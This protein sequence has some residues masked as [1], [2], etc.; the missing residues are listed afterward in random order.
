MKVSSHGYFSK[1]TPLYHKK[2]KDIVVPPSELNKIKKK[3]K[4][5]DNQ[6]ITKAHFLD[7]YV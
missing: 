2:L 6:K 4:Y 1:I 5:F 7:L 3:Y